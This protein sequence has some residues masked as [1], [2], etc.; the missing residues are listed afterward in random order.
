MGD[1]MTNLLTTLDRWSMLV[2]VFLPILIAAVNRHAWPGA[3]KLAVSVLLCF[4]ASAVTVYLQGKWNGHDWVGSLVLVATFAYASYHW[5]WKPSG[6]AP[7]VE[8]ATG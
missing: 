6:V 2:G 7:A 3:V 5:A 4:A 1:S 8:R